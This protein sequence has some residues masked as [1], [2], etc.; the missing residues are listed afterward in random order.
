M[1]EFTNWILNAG[2]GKMSRPNTGNPEVD[3]PPELLIT[4]FDDPIAAIVQSTYPNLLSQLQNGRYFQS[5][6]ILA[7]TVEAVEQINDYMLKL[8]PGEGMEYYSADSIDSSEI[9]DAQAF[10]MIPPEMIPPEFLNIFK[11]SDIPNHKFT[12]KAGTPITLLK[13][14][15]PAGG[16]YN[17]TRL[18]VTR[19]VG[20]P[21]E[22]KNHDLRAFLD[23]LS[24]ATPETSIKV[25]V[26]RMWDTRNTNKQKGLISTDMVLID[27]KANYIHAT[28]PRWDSPKIKTKLQEGKVYVI[29]KFEVSKNRQRYAV[30]ERNSL[31]LHLPGDVTVIEEDCGDIEIPR[32][33]FEFVDFDNL[34]KRN[35]KQVYS[36]VI[37]VV[38]C[39]NPIEE[40]TTV[41]GKVDMMSLQLK[42][43]RGDV[44]KVT[45][46]DE[47]VAIFNQTLKEQMYDAPKPNVAIFTSVTV[48]Q[49]QGELLA[50]SSRSTKIYVNIDIP[51]VDDLIRSFRGDA[52][53]ANASPTVNY[54]GISQ[55]NP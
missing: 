33:I 41:N 14:L 25:R 30:V 2:E 5:R 26:A 3:I 12:L 4:N 28:T 46:W 11:A 50:Q 32:H 36:D 6:A 40:R 18:I 27:E 55:V 44:F 48:K 29:S 24:N 49:Y 39:V 1:Q 34:P 51:E 52:N 13:D 43:G 23:E 47:Y 54:A 35:G 10:D 9:N 8:L 17:G 20:S 45:L 21:E 16:F 7:S 22:N 19:I 31:E 37:G 42:N 53:I 15:D 38:T